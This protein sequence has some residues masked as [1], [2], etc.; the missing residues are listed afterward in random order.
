VA[1][2]EGNGPTE[3]SST[4]RPADTAGFAAGPVDTT[5]ARQRVVVLAGPSGSGKSRLAARFHAAHGWPIFRLDD[6]YRDE[7]DPSMPRSDD[8]GIID[9][10]HPDSWDADRAVAS[11]CELVDTGRTD[12]PVYDI[13]TS[14]AVGHH[15]VTAA[16]GDLIVAEGIFA[17][18]VVDR[19]RACGVLHS[20]WCVHHH[21]AVTFVRRLARDLRE[22]RKPP[23]TLVRRG[24]TLMRAEPEIV[25]RQTELGA[26]PAR[27]SDLERRLSASLL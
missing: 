11:L 26:R 24:L 10:D 9:W 2:D 25:R 15:L 23:V 21:P 5:G 7:D 6:F 14:R 22:R 18:E 19:L 20:A 4:A 1:D 8:L 16:P 3:G 17:A 13:S 12:T 27:A